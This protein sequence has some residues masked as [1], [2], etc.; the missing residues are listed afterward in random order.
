M[1]T[2]SF[3][4]TTLPLVVTGTREHTV[5]IVA[6]DVATGIFTTERPHGLMQDER[7][8]RNHVRLV[9]SA[10]PGGTSS[11]ITYRA[12]LKTAGWQ[13][14]PFQFKLSAGPIQTDSH[15]RGAVPIQPT[16]QGTLPF[17]AF[18]RRDSGN[19]R[20]LDKLISY[21][22]T[23][24]NVYGRTLYSTLYQ[25]VKNP[26]D[27]YPVRYTTLG[28]PREC[29]DWNLTPGLWIYRKRPSEFIRV[30]ADHSR[31]DGQ[32]M[33]CWMLPPTLY[34]DADRVETQL[35]PFA[36]LLRIGFDY[37][38][39]LAH[40][41]ADDDEPQAQELGTI[42]QTRAHLMRCDLIRVDSTPIDIPMR[43]GVP[44][45]SDREPRTSY[46]FTATLDVAEMQDTYIERYWAAPENPTWL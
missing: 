37:Q 33:L 8:E 25:D 2:R 14:S 34:T 40:I 43:E 21:A 36:K 20:A 5:R 26:Q 31:H 18:T 30:S 22:Q 46:G 24:L 13:A 15:G 11:L 9:G 19:D 38:R 27:V 23:Y 10:L 6:V 12:L 35:D 45:A 17:R 32:I 41:E 44:G 42:V 1:T 28:N 29:F 7:D 4:L 16:T 3:G 39:D